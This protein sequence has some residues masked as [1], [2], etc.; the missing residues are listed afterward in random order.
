MPGT[1]VCRA[2]GGAAVGFSM[3]S[4]SPRIPG[5]WC[6]HH[7]WEMSC[8]QHGLL[9]S[10]RVKGHRL[11]WKGWNE[12]ARCHLRAG[13]RDGEVATW[14]LD[15]EMGEDNHAEMGRGGQG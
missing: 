3:C 2:G 11:Q 10:L 12:A 8:P 14:D 15:A 5:H 9:G 7:E 13:V 4:P 1:Q 6:S